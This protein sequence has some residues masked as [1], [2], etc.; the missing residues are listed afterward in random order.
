MLMCRISSLL[1]TS[2]IYLEDL[3]KAMVEYEFVLKIARA[4]P[5]QNIPVGM[6]E[7]QIA[8]MKEGIAAQ[9]QGKKVLI[10]VSMAPKE[11]VR[12]SP[13][14]PRCRHPRSSRMNRSWP[15]R[16]QRACKAFS[17]PRAI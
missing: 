6:F 1:G 13:Y 9:A 7:Q 2:Y 4:N 17:Q 8:Q 15:S 3:P 14:L 5:S 12:N 16:S 11:S 10:D